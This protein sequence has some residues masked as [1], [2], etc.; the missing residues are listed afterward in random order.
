MSET[1]YSFKARCYKPEQF[2]S[3]TGLSK[4]DPREGTSFDEFHLSKSNKKVKPQDTE[5]ENE[6][7]NTSFHAK[8][9]NRNILEGPLFQPKFDKVCTEASPFKLHTSGRK[10]K[11]T[12]EE[13]Q[14]SF[15]ARDMPHYK[16]FEIK[17][18]SSKK[19]RFQEF[20]L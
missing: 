20:D 13:Y 14:K 15:K 17:H 10:R 8:E 1:R 16:F 5:K 19:V 9:L 12:E 4:L 7:F 18:N 11:E 6:V 2:V 3:V